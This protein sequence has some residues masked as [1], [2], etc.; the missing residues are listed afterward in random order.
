MFPNSTCL[1]NKKVEL[2][3]EQEKK[4]GQK[5]R[6][7]EGISGRDKKRGQRRGKGGD[8][9]ETGWTMRTHMKQSKTQQ[10]TG[11]LSGY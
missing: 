10:I 6:S 8:L 4:I 11:H 9:H 2:V 3:T 7:S 5:F 1:V